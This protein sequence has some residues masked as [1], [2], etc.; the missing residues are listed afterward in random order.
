MK[1]IALPIILLL[2]LMLIAGCTDQATPP[3]GMQT[4][5]M[6]YSLHE[7]QRTLSPDITLALPFYLPPGYVFSQGYYLSGQDNAARQIIYVQGEET[8]SLAQGSPGGELFAVQADGTETAVSIDAVPATF[9]AGME[10]N[11]LRWTRHNLTFRLTGTVDREE[12]IR[13]AASIQPA[14]YD[15]NLTPPHDY[16]PP[17]NPLDETIDVNQTVPANNVTVTFISLKCSAEGCEAELR[18][19]LSAVPVMPGTPGESGQSTPV[20]VPP[21]PHGEIWVDNGTSLRTTQSA[22]Y[23]PENGT[24]LFFWR[25]DPIPS[26]ARVL[27]IRIDRFTEYQGERYGPWNFSVPILPNGDE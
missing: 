3:P 1:K 17:S 25:F 26:D 2:S 7:M 16:V 6:F 4:P 8:L 9:I 12:M 21:Q 15:E 18:V 10:K 5:L 24:T 14:P 20:S 13:I 23:R 22:G 19:D 11:Q 27:N